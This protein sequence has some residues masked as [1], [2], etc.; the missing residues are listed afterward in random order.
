MP[1]DVPDGYTLAGKGSM[2]QMYL[3]DDAAGIHSPSASLQ[4]VKPLR[5]GLQI[6]NPEGRKVVVTDDAGKC[7]YDAT[8]AEVT[9][10]LPAGVYVV[11]MGSASGKY[12]VR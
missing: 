4:G 5:G 11:S 6:R 8:T 9:L 2:W 3:S 12:V 10:S 1:T 7:H